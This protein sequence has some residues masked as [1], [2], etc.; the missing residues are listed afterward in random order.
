METRQEF[1][2]VTH[3]DWQLFV[4]LVNDRLAKGWQLHGTHY[5]LPDRRCKALYRYHQG[6]VRE[7]KIDEPRC[8]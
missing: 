7:A 6:L 4:V 2:V 5:A 3:E 8:A 1:D